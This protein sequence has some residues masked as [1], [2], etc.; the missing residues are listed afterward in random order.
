MSQYDKFKRKLKE[1]QGKFVERFKGRS[2]W[3]LT[4]VEELLMAQSAPEPQEEGSDREVQDR[5]RLKD[6]LRRR[7][8]E[9]LN[10]EEMAL[11]T[12]RY[13]SGN[14]LR[15]FRK[16]AAEYKTYDWDIIRRIEKILDRL[17]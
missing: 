7:M 6:E 11:L 10:E 15:S 8:A 2:K 12:A 14:K 4:N 9:R 5:E 16:I 3:M 17:K 1:Q 13:Y